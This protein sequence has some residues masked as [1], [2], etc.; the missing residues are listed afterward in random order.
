MSKMHDTKL[1]FFQLSKTHENATE[2]A[3]KP[4]AINAR[5]QISASHR[6]FRSCECEFK[7]RKVESQC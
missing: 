2:D 3:V 4:P 1:H 7:Y 5:K 6:N